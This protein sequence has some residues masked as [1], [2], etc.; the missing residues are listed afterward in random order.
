MHACGPFD[1][2][3][4]KPND[5]QATPY[6]FLDQLTLRKYFYSFRDIT[7]GGQCPCNGHASECPVDQATMVREWE[8]KCFH[9]AR[10]FEKPWPEKKFFLDSDN[11]KG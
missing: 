1:T 11:D 5:S 10:V 9:R 7:I 6:D 2:Y 8:M 3:P 4:G